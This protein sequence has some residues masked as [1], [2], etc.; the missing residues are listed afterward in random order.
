MRQNGA[1][2]VVGPV[3]LIPHFVHTIRGPNS[4]T[5]T[6]SG[7]GAPPITGIVVAQV[8][9]RWAS[10]QSDCCDLAGRKLNPLLRFAIAN[11]LL[12]NVSSAI[13]CA[14]MQ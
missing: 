8:A 14:S 11:A 4:G 2:L 6:S 3:F 10:N 5:G 12:S 13:F 9:G 7:Q 1:G